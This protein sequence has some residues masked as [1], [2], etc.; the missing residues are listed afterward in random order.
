M[1]AFPFTIGSFPIWNDIQKWKQ[2][3]QS[4]ICARKKE[5]GNEAI[6]LLFALGC[7]I[8]I[9]QEV[10]FYSS[11]SSSN[12]IAFAFQIKVNNFCIQPLRAWE[13]FGLIQLEHHAKCS[14]NIWS[15][16]ILTSCKRCHVHKYHYFFFKNMV[17]IPRYHFKDFANKLNL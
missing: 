1:L 2:L 14:V 16:S 11:F 8:L 9:H 3:N 6:L 7:S 4:P 10:T 17:Q 13:C 12:A 15:L 5:E